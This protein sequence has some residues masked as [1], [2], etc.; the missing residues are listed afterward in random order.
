MRAYVLGAGASYPIY[1]LGGALFKAID[2][3]IQNCGPCVNRFDYQTD[4]PRLKE[5]LN[6]NPNPLL[7][8]AYWNGNIEQ[9]FTVLDL[10][11]GLISDSY[12]SMFRAAKKWRER[13]QGC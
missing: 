3:H 1:P 5:W 11:E 9:I 10:A 7:R 4:W 12:S 8:Q 2:E 6:K 13:S